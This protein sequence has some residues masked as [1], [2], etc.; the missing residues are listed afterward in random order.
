MSPKAITSAL[1][2]AQVLFLPINGQPSN[3]DL[4][5][6][7]NAILPI[8]LKATYDH[9]NNIHNLWGLIASA[10]C[11]L[12]HYG[13][14]FVRPAT[15]L[16]CYDPAINAEASCV[17]R[18]CAE[19]AWAALL[20]DYKAYEAAARS[21]KVFIEAVV[22]NTWIH[23]LCNPETFYSNVT[24]L[25]MF[26]HLPKHCGGLQALDMVSLTIQMSQY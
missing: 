14:P 5:H 26:N 3:D 11:Y 10:D 13:P 23:N 4:V 22:N 25:T 17:D 24:A 6:L 2:A 7:S 8:L 15:R 19:T 18:V 12:H 21:V 20:Q 16:A 9:V 1:T